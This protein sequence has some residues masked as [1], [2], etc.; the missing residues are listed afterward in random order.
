MRARPSTRCSQTATTTVPR[1]GPE[2]TIIALISAAVLL[3]LLV[4]SRIIVAR[5]QRHSESAR[6]TGNGRIFGRFRNDPAGVAL[7]LPNPDIGPGMENL[8]TS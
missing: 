6:V 8:P 4:I 2:R 5:T 7:L 1:H 3:L